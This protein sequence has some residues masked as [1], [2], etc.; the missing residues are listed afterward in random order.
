MIIRFSRLVLAVFLMIIA[1]GIIAAL[2][3][4]IA[5]KPQPVFLGGR[6]FDIRPGDSSAVH[7]LAQDE[8]YSQRYHRPSCDEPVENPYNLQYFLNDPSQLDSLQKP[9]DPILAYFGLLKQASNM[10][11]FIAGCGSI[12]DGD[13]PYPY[14]YELLSSQLQS[15]I[16]LNQFKDSFKGIGH[17]TLLKV[18][19]AYSP[20]GNKYYMFEIE[21]I[22]GSKDTANNTANVTSFAYYYGIIEVVFED[23]GWKL[24]SINILGE[25]FLCAPYHNWFYDSNAVMEIIY[26]ENLNIISE[27]T[28]TERK[29]DFIHIYATGGG[30]DF[31]FD[32]VVL[33][34]GHEILLQENV[35]ENGEYVP[36]NLLP[37]QYK[38]YKLSILIF[39]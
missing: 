1:F 34:N 9:K 23:T 17:I 13:I 2:I 5:P 27:I 29:G 4:I 10:Q 11:G 30:K 3:Y 16:T 20:D 19:P 37:E 14:A 39:R 21:V 36:V 25:D 6:V 26:K 32:F 35:L 18:Y 7:T 22:K 15:R 8:D 31:R 12:G 24:Q 38:N 33:T 28:R